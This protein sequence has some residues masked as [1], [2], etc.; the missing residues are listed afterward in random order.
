[1]A[2]KDVYVKFRKFDGEI[3]L[4]VATEH[5]KETAL[6][7]KKRYEKNS[8]GKLSVKISPFRI[9]EIPHV[10]YYVWVKP[11]KGEKMSWDDA[12]RLAFYGVIL[13]KLPGSK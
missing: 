5:N 11:I 2:D 12:T 8:K 1:M 10:C 3:Y 13:K 4:K 7:D 9:P 6:Q